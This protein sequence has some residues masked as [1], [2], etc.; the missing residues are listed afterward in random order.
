MTNTQT[1]WSAWFTMIDDFTA[2]AQKKLKNKN[3]FPWKFERVVGGIIM[4]GASCPLKKDGSPDFR[5]K[6][7]STQCVVIYPIKE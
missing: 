6:D 4:T 3:W 5:K 2:Y 1:Q 7:K